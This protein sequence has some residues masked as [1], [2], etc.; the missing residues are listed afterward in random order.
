MLYLPAEDPWPVLHQR[1]FAWADI[2]TLNFVPTLNETFVLYRC[3]DPVQ[4]CW[5]ATGGKRLPFGLRGSGW[6]LSIH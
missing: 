5:I 6:W 2:L 3:R 1:L 4:M